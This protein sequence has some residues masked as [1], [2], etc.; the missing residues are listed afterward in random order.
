MAELIKP[1]MGIAKKKKKKGEITSETI[2][3]ALMALPFVVSV[4]VFSY[5][6]LLGWAIAFVDYI[7]GR[8]IFESN[9]VGFKYFAQIFDYGTDFY[10]ILFN[11]FAMSFL[12][13][14]LSPISIIFALMLNEVGN[15]RVKKFVQI[16]TT[17]PNFISFI[18]V[19]SL[20]VAMFSVDDGFI[21]ILLK[22]LG[23]IT[24]GYNPMGDEK[25]TWFFQVCVVNVWKALGWSSIVYLSAISSIP[26][27]LYEAAEIDGAGRLSQAIHITIPGIL[28]TYMVLLLLSIASMLG[29][30]SFEQIFVFYN[31]IVQPKIETLDYYVYKVG[32]IKYD[33]S[34]STAIG[35]FKSMVSISLLFS[36]NA[37]AKKVLGRNII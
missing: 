15:I 3:I 7:P 35:I 19:Y 4:I 32:L 21:N 34:L 25:I 18:I 17:F 36:A 31:A 27:E 10:R 13:I 24:K 22:N 23:L 26:S 2:I 11:T 30:A 29:G 20:F 12:S 5:V 6:P 16:G 33:F 9:F 1:S 37:I 8:S 14:L 28:P